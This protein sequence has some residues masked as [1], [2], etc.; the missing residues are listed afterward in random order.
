MRDDFPSFRSIAGVESRLAAASLARIAIDFDAQPP[1][2]LAEDAIHPIPF[3]SDGDGLNDVEARLCESDTFSKSP[4]LGSAMAV[5]DDLVFIP[6]SGYEEV[7]FATPP[8]GELAQLRVTN[9]TS[10]A[11]YFAEDYP[12]L[13]PEGDIDVW[14]L[15]L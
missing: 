11:G 14:E 9:P 12:Y 2:L 7:I 1:K 13:P 3:D 5:S 8:N 6:A 15:K 4:V 10:D